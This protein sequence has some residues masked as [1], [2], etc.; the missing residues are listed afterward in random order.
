MIKIV[1]RVFVNKSI[2]IDVNEVLGIMCVKVQ[3]FEMHVNFD[4]IMYEISI[5]A[6]I[7]TKY[8]II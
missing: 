7:G 5:K 8:K 2:L 4:L 1:K 3:C 6:Y